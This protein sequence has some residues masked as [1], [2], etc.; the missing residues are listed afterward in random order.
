MVVFPLREVPSAFTVTFS[1]MVGISATGKAIIFHKTFHS[2]HIIN[3]FY[4]L[5]MF[6]VNILLATMQHSALLQGAIDCAL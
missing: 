2:K 1:G 4:T 6:R 3:I 5:A